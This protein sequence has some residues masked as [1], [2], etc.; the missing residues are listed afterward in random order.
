MSDYRAIPVWLI[1]R[2]ANTDLVVLRHKDGTALNVSYS[3]DGLKWTCNKWKQSLYYKNAYVSNGKI[4]GSNLEKSPDVYVE[5]FVPINFS[6]AELF[7]Q[8]AESTWVGKALK[9]YYY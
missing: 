8:Q 2:I 7:K 3:E 5:K 1:D 6:E 4:R 9:L